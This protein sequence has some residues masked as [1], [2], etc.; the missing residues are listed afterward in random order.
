MQL[1]HLGIRMRRNKLYPNIQK[2]VQSRNS[3]CRFVTGRSFIVI[4]GANACQSAWPIKHLDSFECS[5]WSFRESKNM[6]FKILNKGVLGWFRKW[7]FWLF[8]THDVIAHATR[9]VSES[10][11]PNMWFQIHTDIIKT[12][13]N[14]KRFYTQP[15]TSRW[16]DPRRTF[17]EASMVWVW[18][19][20]FQTR[21]SPSMPPVTWRAYPPVNIQKTI[22]NHHFSMGN[23]SNLWPCSMANC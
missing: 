16:L 22:E 3:A 8:L 14:K 11:Q 21:T 2:P 6:G 18:K 12:K 1:L 17:S 7:H 19:P 10:H 13:K 15:Q 4:R 9:T 5:W 23:L 20:M